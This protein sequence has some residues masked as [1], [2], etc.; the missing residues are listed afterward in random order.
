VQRT[1]GVRNRAFGLGIA[2][3]ITAGLL[4][5]L[6]IGASPAEAKKCANFKVKG[7]PYELQTSK[8]GCSEA[9]KLAKQA[10]NKNKPPAGFKC[11]GGGFRD[12]STLCHEKD[13]TNR[14]FE[15]S[16]PH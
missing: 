11:L 5:A 12:D 3:L 1:E 9:T 2:G 15:Y 13:N 7:V 6:A 4:L 8:L 14:W 16:E 10:Y